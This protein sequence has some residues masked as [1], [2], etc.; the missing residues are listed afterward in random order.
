VWR[1]R[2]QDSPETALP[3]ELK[4]GLYDMLS[5][6]VARQLKRRNVSEDVMKDSAFMPSAFD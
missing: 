4:R 1:D 6:D 3:I 2:Q 5:S